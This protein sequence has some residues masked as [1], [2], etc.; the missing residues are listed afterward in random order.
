MENVKPPFENIIPQL[1]TLC[2]QAGASI[3]QLYKKAESLEVIRKGDG[4]PVTEADHQSHRLL[5]QGLKKITPQIPVISE[6]D[7]ASWDIK[8]PFYWLVDPLDGTSG[9]IHRNGQFCISI[10]LME[11]H[12]AILGLIHLPLTGETF[13]GY[14]NTAIKHVSG[15]SMPINTRPFPPAGAT[16]L[17]SIHDMKSKEKWEACLQGTPIDKVEP[18][19]SAIKFC[20]IAEGAA[21]LYLRFVPC[22]EW[23]TAAGQILVEA[24]GGSMETLDGEP[25]LYGKPHLKNAAFKVSGQKS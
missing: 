3:A 2:E 13:Y 20:R 14:E 15:H 24:A 25:F 6:E 23:D 11:N 8:S 19:H 1:I 17:L 12:K 10:A 5:A 7:E 22:K 18:L 21:D 16:L 4:S 9:F